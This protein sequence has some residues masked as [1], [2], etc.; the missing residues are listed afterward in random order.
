MKNG[1]KVTLAALLAIAAGVCGY[2]M[3]P[4]LFHN[5]RQKAKKAKKINDSYI[6]HTVKGEEWGDLDALQAKLRGMINQRLKG[7]SPKQ[8]EEF[9]KNPENRLILAQYTLTH[10]EKDTEQKTANLLQQHNNALDNL[11]K[12]IEKTKQAFPAG[13]PMPPKLAVRQER[14]ESRAGAIGRE[15]AQP[16]SLSEVVKSPNGAKFMETLGNNLDWVEQL[17]STGERPRPGSA[18]SILKTLSEKNPSMMKDKMDRDIATAT[19]AEFARAGWAQENAVKRADFYSKSWK[20]GNLNKTFGSLPFWQRRMVLGLKGRGEVEGAGGND[21]AGNVSSLTYSQDNAHLPAY[22][23]TGACWQAPYRLHNIYGESIHGSGY[24]E[25]FYDLYGTPSDMNYNEFTRVVGG[26][27]GGLSHYGATTATANGIPATTCGEPG[28]CSYVVLV[29]DKWTPGYSLSWERGM[30]WQVFE[31]N[32]KFSALDMATKLFSEGEQKNT[33]LSQAMQN[34]GNVYAAD[35][36]DKAHEL[37]SGAVTTQPLNY[38]A[39]RDYAKFLAAQKPQ[40]AAAWTKLCEQINT[41][42]APTHAEMAA[43]LLKA[44]VYPHLA[45]ALGDDKQALSNA[46]LGFWSNVRGMGPDPDWDKGFHGRWA[47]EALCNAQLS[48]MGINAQKNPAVKDY[49]GSVASKLSANTDYMPVM[50]SWGNSLLEKMDK[51]IQSDFLNSMVGG[52]SGDMSEEAREN[53]IKPVILAAE[54]TGDITSF[55]A[56]GRTLPE[57]YRN[58]AAKLPK[59]DPFPEKL[60]SQGGII[61]ASSTSNFDKPCEHWGVLEPGIGGSFHT[62]KDKDA[63]VVV[64]LPKQANL[65]GVVICTT[66][67]NLNRLDNMKIQISE[68]GEDND[69]KDVATLGPC[70][71]QVIRVDLNTSRPLAKY[72]RILRPGGPDFFHLRGI[73]IYGKPAA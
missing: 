41:S 20:K 44:H 66:T 25:S 27:C 17:N 34:L 32:N 63:W 11:Q 71:Q 3:Q 72:V 65:T 53:M 19:A 55:Q 60:V 48:L 56:I 7:T 14:Q 6:G 24:N 28:H 2:H 62:A 37:F 18:A 47:V 13:T 61:R 73:F 49:F 58:P 69:W 1:K 33:K 54:R 22:R 42:V 67:G 9:L 59:V 12:N 35:E 45:K 10:N 40:D 30:H 16:H 38:Y 15:L 23:Y 64:T 43:E 70:K 26:V 8:V 51:S 36:P 39:W 68:T 5:V 29:G 46:L 50:L 4:S 57:K 31:G 52:I 21:L